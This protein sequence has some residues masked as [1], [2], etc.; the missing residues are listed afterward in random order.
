[1]S[2]EREHVSTLI[3][4]YR[5]HECLYKV[6]SALY[7]NK[8]ARQQAL[9]QMASVISDVRPNTTVNDVKTKINSL[10]TQFNKECAKLRSKPS[11][12]SGEVVNIK[13]W[14]FEQLLFLQDQ[15]TPRSS[16][17]NLQAQGHADWNESIEVVDEEEESVNTN[18]KPKPTR[19]PL[20]RKAG[21]P[22]ELVEPDEAV[23]PI[24]NVETASTPVVVS[25]NRS[26]SVSPP[27]KK[28]LESPTKKNLRSLLKENQL[29][30]R[31]KIRSLQQI[32]RRKTKKCASM[33][34]IINSLK[35]RNY[36]AEEDVDVLN[37]TIGPGKEIFKTTAA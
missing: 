31:K 15:S 22:I 30:Y 23:E 35:A 13:L 8:S 21:A 37:S 36:I 24:H 32:N 20:K 1:M 5:E 6:K 10:R 12:C 19:R 9:E 18:D 7:H 4:L 16:T 34:N 29:K 11:G 2:W 33:K 28:M 14:C 17:S 3:D 26:T 27:H 25:T